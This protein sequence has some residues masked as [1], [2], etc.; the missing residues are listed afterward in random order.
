M[1]GKKF[2]TLVAVS[3]VASLVASGIKVAMQK[4]K[5]DF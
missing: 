3:V 4:Q 2:L 1:N 5:A